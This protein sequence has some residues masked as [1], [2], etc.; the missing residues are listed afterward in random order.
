MVL[1]A[2]GAWVSL[3]V[4]HGTSVEG[5]TVWETAAAQLPAALIYLAVPA[6]VFVLRPSATIA[7]GW[8]LLG[9]GVVLGIFG[10]MVGLDQDVRH[11]SP[12]S[13]TPV[14]N[15]TT[16]DWTG[17]WW[18][19]DIAVLAALTALLGMKRRAITTA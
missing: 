19:L 16:R 13:R 5:W 7:M 15:G 11:I 17:A 12:F 4:S 10:G 8:A 2:F 3:T 9:A 1:T 14:P 18:M 6:L